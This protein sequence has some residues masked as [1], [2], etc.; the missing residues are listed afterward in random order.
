VGRAPVLCQRRGGASSRRCS[1]IGWL[2]GLHPIRNLI[3]RAFFPSRRAHR[4]EVPI[5]EIRKQ[6][7]PF[8]RFSL[9][10]YPSVADTCLELQDRFGIDVN[11]LLFLL[12][13]AHRGRR[14]RA[15][16]VRGILSAVEGWNR[17][18][19]VPLRS[20]RRFLRDAPS[21]IDHEAAAS[22]RQH[23]KQVEL[24]AERLQQE[25]LYR[26]VPLEDLGEPDA[27]P[28][29]A[30]AANVEAYAAELGTAFAPPLVDSLLAG[31]RRLQ[32][33]QDA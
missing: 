20:V 6:Q 13:A 28:E 1:R 33:G 14:V 25:G 21:F 16:E 2:F 30:A 18:V 27:S 12:W 23:V 32:N 10:I 8:W 15:D 29:A 9:R 31:F 5:P 26:F 17:E 24:E 7:S 3:R 11:V 19:V 22:L 4:A